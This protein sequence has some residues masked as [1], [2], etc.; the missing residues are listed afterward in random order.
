VY[1]HRNAFTACSLV[2]L[3]EAKGLSP[4]VVGNDRDSSLSEI[5][6]LKMAGKRQRFAAG[7]TT[8][9]RLADSAFDKLRMTN[10]GGRTVSKSK[11]KSMCKRIK[12]QLGN[13]PKQRC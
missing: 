12:R 8:W 13:D 3:S 2:T 10:S 11:S 9:P 4:A 5:T 7:D 1:C 6:T